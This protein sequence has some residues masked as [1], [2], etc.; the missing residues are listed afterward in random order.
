VAPAANDPSFRLELTGPAGTRTFTLAEL[1]ALPQNISRLPI[2]CVEG[3]SVNA[4]W[5][6]IRLR[7]LIAIAGGDDSFQVQVFSLQQ[8]GYNHSVAAPPHA[9]DPLTLLALR[10]NGETLNLD[11]GYPCRLIAPNRPGVMQTKWVHRILV[12]RPPS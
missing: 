12:E 8:S 9:R 5:T 10:L 7:D 11:H 6:G 3:W 1:E 2:T 4:V